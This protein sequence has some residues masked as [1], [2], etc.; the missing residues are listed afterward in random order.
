MVIHVFCCMLSSASDVLIISL[1]GLRSSAAHFDRAYRRRTCKSRAMIELN[2]GVA[3]TCKLQHHECSFML[4]CVAFA[5]DFTANLP[6]T[7]MSTLDELMPSHCGHS[8]SWLEQGK[9][10]FAGCIVKRLHHFGAGGFFVGR[11][12]D[13]RRSLA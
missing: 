1:R 12:F 11:V 5:G 7:C 9:G 4:C 13:L 6:T 8:Y 10:N 3:C 2:A